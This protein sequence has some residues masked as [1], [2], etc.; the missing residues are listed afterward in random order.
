MERV[1]RSQT[2][3]ELRGF[4]DGLDVRRQGDRR[5]HDDSY[6]VV[7]STCVDGGAFP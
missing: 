7:L 3:K 1:R 2:Q 6:I 5:V 4:I